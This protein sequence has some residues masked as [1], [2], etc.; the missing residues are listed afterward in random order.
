M[1]KLARF[2]ELVAAGVFYLVI[3]GAAVILAIGL[4]FGVLSAEMNFGFKCG[5]VLLIGVYVVIIFAFIWEATR[6]VFGRKTTAN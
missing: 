1:K 3:L 6:K 5:M 2:I 4:I